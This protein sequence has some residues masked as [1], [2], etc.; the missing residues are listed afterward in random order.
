[1]GVNSC[2]NGYSA[3]TSSDGC[4]ARDVYN[5]TSIPANANPL[6]SII[7]VPFSHEKGF[8]VENCNPLSSRNK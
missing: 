3:E 5:A 1:M 2:K 6:T 7:K 8:S 4:L